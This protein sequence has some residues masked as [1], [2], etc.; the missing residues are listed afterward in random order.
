LSSAE[1]KIARRSR[2]AEMND[3]LSAPWTVGGISVPEFE[4]FWAGE[5]EV[6][7]R[8]VAAETADARRE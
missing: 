6:V 2:C 5:R 8:D 7:S 3:N 1:S 4:R